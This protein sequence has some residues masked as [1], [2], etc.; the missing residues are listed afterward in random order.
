MGVLSPSGIL[1][2]NLILSPDQLFFT[3]YKSIF[4]PLIDAK[5]PQGTVIGVDRDD[6]LAVDGAHTLPFSDITKT[7]TLNKI[8]QV[9][10]GQRI[11]SVIS[12]MA[13]N[14]IGQGSFDHDAIIHLQTLA[15]DFSRLHLATDG[16]FLCKIWFGDSTKEFTAG[17]EKYFK[18]VKLIKPNASRV[19]SAEIFIFCSGFKE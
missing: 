14:S 18:L 8:T 7:S 9:L 12:D 6:L 3:N 11:N 2:N 19:D 17:L 5:K 13:P 15:L 16:C 10:S 4:F 1:K